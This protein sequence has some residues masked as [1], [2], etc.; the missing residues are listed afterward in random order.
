M[1]ITLAAFALI[2]ALAVPVQGAD[3]QSWGFA[4]SG[5][6]G[7]L[8]YGVPESDIVTI[9]FWCEMLSRR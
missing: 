8:A 2:L 6:E 5:K 7:V 4:Q 1:R 3:K 9:A